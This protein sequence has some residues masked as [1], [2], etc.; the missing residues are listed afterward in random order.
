MTAFDLFVPPITEL[1][2]SPIWDVDEQRLYWVDSTGGAIYR[3]DGAGGNIQ[4]WKMPGMVGAISLRTAGGALVTLDDGIYTFDFESSELTKL[5]D[6][7]PSTA[8]RLNDGKVDRQGRFITGT[9]SYALIN[10]STNWL[11][12]K[13]ET[14]CSLY[15]LDPDLV[16]KTV[17]SNIGITNGPCFSPDGATMY[18]SDSWADEIYAF[19]YDTATGELSRQRVFASYVDDKGVTGQGQPDGGTVD[20]EGYV[21]SATVYGGEIR[22]YAPDGT[23]DRRI[24]TPVLKPTSVTFGGADLD[25]LFVTTM[26]NPDLPVPYPKDGPL[27]GSIFA[28]RGLGVTGVPQGRFRG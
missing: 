8:S 11:V 28:V 4:V 21:W 1:A 26:A 12:G 23:L 20:A 15:R 16:V 19:D 18:C 7:E 22:R 14:G 10:P 25:V 2:E 13:I 3:A 24:Q 6:P 5:V 27:A 9:M 17:H